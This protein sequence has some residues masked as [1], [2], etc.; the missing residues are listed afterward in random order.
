MH[1][2]DKPSRNAA[3]DV[4]HDDLHP[5][6]LPMISGQ[7]TLRAMPEWVNIR[8]LVDEACAALGRQMGECHV[9][10]VTDIPR[11]LDFF[12][13]RRMLGSA[14]RNLVANACE[15]MPHGG[16]LVITSSIGRYG[17]E[18]EVADS[19]P[20]LT[21]ECRRRAFEPQ[22]TTK[23]GASGMGL[24]TVWRIAHAHGGDVV[25]ANCPEGGAAFTLRLPRDAQRAAA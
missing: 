6:T 3:H 11:S 1:R 8:Q 12:V 20:G 25:A 10:T 16:R 23:H 7:Q 17:L 14:V 18:L 9:E 5:A 24:A 15:A 13:D 4:D 19:G 21:D 2:P 22:F